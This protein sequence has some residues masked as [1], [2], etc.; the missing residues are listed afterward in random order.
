MVRLGEGAYRPSSFKLK[1]GV[2]AR[3]TFIRTSD[4]NCGQ[5]VLLPAY[6]ISRDL[7]LNT[8]VTIR[9]TPKK[10]G[11]FTFTCGMQ[12]LRGRIIVQ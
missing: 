8:P 10:T 12:M 2:P 1:K 9:F 5:T 4:K 11:S 7:A 3:I 6:G